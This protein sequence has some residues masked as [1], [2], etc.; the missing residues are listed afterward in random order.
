MT[1]SVTV[2]ERVEGRLLPAHPECYEGNKNERGK[3]MEEQLMKL[4]GFLKA[5]GQ[6]RAGHVLIDKLALWDAI[7]AFTAAHGPLIPGGTGADN[8]DLVKS[9]ALE[10]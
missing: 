2:W 5:S 10:L 4:A 3:N 8:V 1:D 7:T 6:G 9:L